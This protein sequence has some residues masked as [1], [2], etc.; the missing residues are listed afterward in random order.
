MC[1]TKARK[2]RKG[3]E[4]AKE[5]KRASEQIKVLEKKDLKSKKQPNKNLQ[6]STE[7]FLN[8]KCLESK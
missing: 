1:K 2:D 3:R 7:S 8:W 4:K 5:R 6:I